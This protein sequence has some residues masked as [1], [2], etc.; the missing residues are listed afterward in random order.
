MADLRTFLLAEAGALG[1]AEARVASVD[2]A[3]DMQ[4]FDAFLARGAEGEMG[5]LRTGRD[6]RAQLR[7][8]LPGAQSVLVL[9]F[10]FG[11]LAPDPGGLT[12][13]VASYAWGRDYHNVVL[14]RLR[15]LQSRLNMAFPGIGSY[16]SLDSRPVY[17]RA[18]AARAGL[19]FVG[20][21]HCQVIPSRGA[22]FFLATLAVDRE[23]APDAPLGD[24]CGR[25]SRCVEACPTA[26]LVAG[27][28]IEATRC[29]S[30]LTIEADAPVPLPLRP[31]LGR[32]VFGC[33][34]CTDSCPHEHAPTVD[35]A[36][37]PRDAWLD[38][39]AILAMDDAQLVARFEGSPIRRAAGPRLRR[40]AAL[41]LGNIGDTG[42][43]PA[44]ERATAD[45]SPV[46]AE[47]A[48]W[49]LGRLTEPGP[50]R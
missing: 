13:R 27:A 42:A 1:F 26:A 15:K 10:D 34:D 22:T 31:L 35:P 14:K 11:G 23:M 8:L 45:P 19:G 5:W 12:G 29:I 6:A 18:W 25:C 46:V 49:S 21:N 7:S 4:H 50:G 33:D 43:V 28:G 37:A 16:A 48:R 38:L 40:N 39:P 47:A 36:L 2:P 17:E 24:H 3:L 32:W 9:A 20:K 44:L 30:Y 41:V